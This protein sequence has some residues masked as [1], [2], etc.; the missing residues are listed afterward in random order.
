MRSPQRSR[1]S[2]IANFFDIRPHPESRAYDIAFGTDMD[3][4]G[5][6]CPVIRRPRYR[7]GLV[8][9]V[10]DP[11]INPD[12]GF[13]ILFL[14]CSNMFHGVDFI[15][16]RD[17]QSI[18]MDVLSRFLDKQAPAH[19]APPLY[20]DRNNGKIIA[21]LNMQKSVRVENASKLQ[22]RDAGRYRRSGCARGL[23]PA[24]W[25]WRRR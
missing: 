2:A 23:S 10:T 17:G 19:V 14:R 12:T 21:F 6:L 3:I 13:P 5:G 16:L 7:R 22:D 18:T 11:A 8:V 15:G 20:A 1:G 25:Q 24:R 9:K 4:L